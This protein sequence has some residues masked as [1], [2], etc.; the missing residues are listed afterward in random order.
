[1]SDYFRTISRLERERAARARSEVSDPGAGPPSLVPDTVMPFAELPLVGQR[2]AYA[3]LLDSLMAR[4]GSI[5]RPTVVIAG[6]TAGDWLRPVLDGLLLEARE[7]GLTP[8]LGEFA[9]SGGRRVLRLLGPDDS[10]ASHIRRVSPDDPPETS[11]LALEVAGKPLREAA[12]RW[13][14]TRT[15]GRDL[16]IIEG[17]PLLT[18]VD[19]A[20][21][22]KICDGLVIVVEPLATARQA[23]Q[24]AVERARAADC[25]ILGLV[26]NG[27]KEWLP[28][29]LQKL[30]A[31]S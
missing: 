10:G 12:T 6:V 9:V 14:D 15:G 20:L 23:L 4:L 25:P 7:R 22:A 31:G 28:R 13:L 18:S 21:L 29:W 26:M 30:F 17:P 16:I 2:R 24:E 3:T 1:M 19:S 8:L 27:T 11:S 5:E